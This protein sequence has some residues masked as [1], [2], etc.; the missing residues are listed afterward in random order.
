ME[1]VEPSF[2]YRVQAPANLLCGCVAKK[3][4]P[5]LL[6]FDLFRQRLCSRAAVQALLTF[7]ATIEA[8]PCRYVVKT[9][10]LL[11]CSLR[12]AADVKNLVTYHKATTAF[13]QKKRLRKLPDGAEL[14]QASSALQSCSQLC[15]AVTNGHLHGAAAQELRKHVLLTGV[16]E[17]QHIRAHALGNTARPT[18]KDGPTE[19]VRN[20]VLA[21]AT[22]CMRRCDLSAA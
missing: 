18:R 10:T 17:V 5:Q 15:D 11:E 19:L 8:L 16:T 14:A 12:C 22:Q 13:N 3:H 9:N 21:V 4:A 6:C 1:D 2:F 7:A 20:T